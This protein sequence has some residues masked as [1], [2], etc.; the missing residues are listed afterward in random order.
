MKNSLNLYFSQESLTLTPIE[1]REKS[2]N[3]EFDIE[4]VDRPGGLLMAALI[5]CAKNKG[6][7]IKDL[8]IELN[9]DYGYINQLRNGTRPVKNVGYRFS[10]DCANFLNVPRTTIL[11]LVGVISHSDVIE[12]K[13]MLA[14]EISQAMGYICN[15]MVWGHLVTAEI[16]LF[17]EFSHFVL[18]KLYEAAT[19][20]VLLNKSLTIASLQVELDNLKAVQD[21]RIRLVKEHVKNKKRSRQEKI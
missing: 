15:D 4:E 10:L 16:R 1:C 14:A 11:M 21:N 19:G 2:W 13:S 3:W 12:C 7:I 8:A 18:I 6:M 9:V 20:K 17:D 5:A